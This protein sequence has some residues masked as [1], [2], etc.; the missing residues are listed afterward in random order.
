MPIPLPLLGWT[1]RRIR[2]LTLLEGKSRRKFPTTTS[3]FLRTMHEAI[4]SL[5]ARE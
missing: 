2:L 3:S 1:Y 5:R 4:G